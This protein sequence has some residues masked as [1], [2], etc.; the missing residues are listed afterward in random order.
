M[1]SACCCEAPTVVYPRQKSLR[2]GG[3]IKRPSSFRKSSTTT[4][5]TTTQQRNESTNIKEIPIDGDTTSV[6]AVMMPSVPFQRRAEEAERPHTL[7]R[8]PHLDAAIINSDPQHNNVL[9]PARE[10][11]SPVEIPR[12]TVMP[13]TTLAPDN[14]NINSWQAEGNK[15]DPSTPHFEPMQ[16]L[17]GQQSV[18]SALRTLHAVG[19]GISSDDATPIFTALPASFFRR[20][21]VA[22]P[23]RSTSSAENPL[24]ALTSSSGRI[25][26]LERM[27][28]GGTYE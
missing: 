26:R 7:R 22:T 4:S 8:P 18:E 28:S 24:G 17:G 13:R 27:G 16:L 20:A 6:A 5:T 11:S 14:T 2:G 15:D 12:S 21:S 23:Q 1:G 25:L 10:A 3:G 19:S 9:S